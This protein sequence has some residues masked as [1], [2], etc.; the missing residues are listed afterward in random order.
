MEM[1]PGP[2][3]L[4]ES[5]PPAERSLDAEVEATPEDQERARLLA[6]EAAN[7]R[8]VATTAAFALIAVAIMVGVFLLTHDA[9]NDGPEAEAAVP[10]PSAPTATTTA[11]TPS[12][13]QQADLD[14]V[15][16]EIEAFVA[17]ER[18]L[19]FED[20]VEVVV[21]GRSDY[22]DAAR[23]SFDVTEDQ[24]DGYLTQHAQVYQALGL[25]EPGVEPV[26][27]MRELGAVSSTGFYDLET[28][29][30]VMG[31]GELSPLFEMT[32]AHELTHA[33]DDQHFDLDRPELFERSDERAAAFTALAEG[34]ARRVELAYQATLSEEDRASIEN[35]S[36]TA[37]PN[38][39]QDAVPPI[40]LYEQQFTYNDGQDLVQSLVDDGGS[41]AVDRA[42]RHPP[43]TSEQVLEPDTYLAGER[44]TSVPIPDADG[45]AVAEGVVGQSTLD[46]LTS[47][48]RPADEDPPEWDGDRYV[49]WND[50]SG[51]CVRV[52]IDGDAAG[53]EEQLAG[54]ATEVSAEV[55]VGDDAVTVTT[56][57]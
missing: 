30:V 26:S 57:H 32:L 45:D 39:D 53:L 25:W 54:W 8:L 46:V 12:T 37:V 10:P 36:A 52:E 44:P 22:E 3:A 56:C 51:F 20:D 1:P 18:G 21:L 15:V 6:D 29:Q 2:P 31:I 9:S 50:G 11:I 16:D 47:L 43:T 4:G 24:V 17:D 35:D 27:T 42:F 38:F 28:K 23:A 19:D 7:R 13:I 55:D 14:A 34:D 41:A 49:L 40:L 48:E 5:P 33:L